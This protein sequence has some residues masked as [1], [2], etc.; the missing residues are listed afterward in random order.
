MQ[1]TIDRKKNPNIGK[2]R[3]THRRKTIAQGIIQ[4]GMELEMIQ[5]WLFAIAQMWEVGSIPPVLRGISRK[6]QVEVLFKISQPEKSLQKV[7]EIL[8][9][10]YSQDWVKSLSRAGLH[11]AIE[12][13]S[14]IEEIQQIVKPEKIN[15]VQQQL[16]K[17]ELEIIGMKIGDF[18]PTPESVCQQMIKLANIQQNWRILEPSAGSGN[19]AEWLIQT[20]SN[21]QLEVVE[22]NYI[23]RQI[24]Q[25]KG[26]NLIGKNFLE[27]HPTHLY[28]ACIMNPPFCELVEH[29]YH[30]WKLLISNGVLVSVV[31]ESVFFNRKYK[32]FKEWLKANNAYIEMVDKNAFLN[33]TNPTGVAT[34]IIKIIKP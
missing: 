32:T 21:I 11:T 33:S 29:I 30:A 26:F 24:L 14:A 20:H 1:S 7:Q 10:E 28:N 23:L 16:N 18:F 8:E 22:V 31:P 5:S 27:F 4:E 9:D 19:I 15:P 13:V 25:L 17:L 6:S 34:R 12:I 2:Q 3:A